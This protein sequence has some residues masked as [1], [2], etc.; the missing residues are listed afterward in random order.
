MA[1]AKKTAKKATA[2]KAASKKT[3]K[4]A[5]KKAASKKATAKKGA[6]KAAKKSTRK[7]TSKA[8]AGPAQLVVASK[9]KD[10]VK[11]QDVRMS[12][13]FVE[14]LNSEVDALVARA[15]ARAKDNKRGTVRPQ[16]L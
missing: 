11:T 15:V 10:A 13:D 7:A 5:T 3:T 9:V 16:D 4:K 2:K 12:S 1:A 8:A 14:A 6:K